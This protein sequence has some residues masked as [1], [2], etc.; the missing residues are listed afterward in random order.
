[1]ENQVKDGSAASIQFYFSVTLYPSMISSTGEKWQGLMLVLCQGK[2]SESEHSLPKRFLANY[3]V[4]FPPLTWNKPSPASP[5]ACLFL[6]LQRLVMPCSTEKKAG[7]SEM[8]V[9]VVAKIQKTHWVRQAISYWKCTKS[10]TTNA[11]T[12]RSLANEKTEGN[13]QYFW[14]NF[15]SFL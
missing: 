2:S 15:E 11:Q 6:W 9:V 13:K 4:F 10:G 8:F 14:S 5:H 1:M 12:D 7:M 3:K